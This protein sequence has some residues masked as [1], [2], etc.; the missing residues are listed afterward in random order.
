[1]SP[2][3]V[4]YPRCWSSMKWMVADSMSG[5][6]GVLPGTPPALQR[7][8]RFSTANLCQRR[9]KVTSTC[10]HSWRICSA[11]RSWVVK[12]HWSI[13]GWE[14]S[15][16]MGLRSCPKFTVYI[17]GD[18]EKI[19]GSL[20]AS[21]DRIALL[22]GASSVRTMSWYSCVSTM[23]LDLSRHCFVARAPGSFADKTPRVTIT[24]TVLGSRAPTTSVAFSGH[25]CSDGTWDD[26][27]SGR[28]VIDGSVNTGQCRTSKRAIL[29]PL[30]CSCFISGVGK[31]IIQSARAA[32]LMYCTA[33]SK[34][35]WP[36]SSPGPV[37]R[38]KYGYVKQYSV[39]ANKH[40]STSW[41]WL[42]CHSDSTWSKQT[43]S[44]VPC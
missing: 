14:S 21:K 11:R 31:A 25:I 28:T 26:R 41:S 34:L 29:Y 22:S 16:G 7:V 35:N 9:Q 13:P 23:G 33:A 12:C 1:M 3:S 37:P 6:S 36:R 4:M 27:E 20:Q 32:F 2:R 17:T 15:M 38:F 30:R 10:P 40:A 44:K 19:A 43:H 24:Y 42:T 8:Y 39:P 18:W 5:E